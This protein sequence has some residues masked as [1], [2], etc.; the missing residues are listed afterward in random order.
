M[1]PGLNS[2][3]RSLQNYA[4]GQQTHIDDLLLQRDD[5]RDFKDPNWKNLFDSTLGANLDDLDTTEKVQRGLNPIDD[6][7]T[8]PD[9]V[10]LNC[11]VMPESKT[12]NCCWNFRCKKIFIRSE[13][14]EA[15]EF[16]TSA[17]ANGYD[18]LV[19]GGR[20]GIGLSLSACITGS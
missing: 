8:L 12:L 10:P 2:T 1:S 14:K 4:S 6:S 13:Y 19:V 15:E 11:N 9:V 5:F 17:C 3:L 7:L 18:A 20:P 16:A